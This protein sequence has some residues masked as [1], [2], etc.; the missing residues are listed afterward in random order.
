MCGIVGFIDKKLSF[1]KQQQLKIVENMLDLIK[2]RGGDSCGAYNKNSV[3]TGHT[4]LS[5]VDT[6]PKATQPLFDP[7]SVL[8]LNGEIYNHLKL[9]TLL[10]SD[11]KMHSHSDTHTLFGLLKKLP[12][13]KVLNLIQGMYAFSYF[14]TN[15]NQLALAIDKFSIKPLYYVDTPDYFAWASEMKAFKA[16][17]NFNFEFEDSS[18]VEYLNFRYIYGKKT[19]I[20]KVFK[21]CAGEYLIFDLNRRKK[22][23]RT[24]YK[25][26]RHITTN[27]KFSVDHLNNSVKDNLMGDVSPGV[28]LSGGLDSSLITYF[29]N[30]NSKHKPHTFSIGLKETAWNEFLY[31]NTISHDLKTKHH[32][33]LFSKYDFKN[34]FEKITYHLDEP[35]V[36]PNTI[37]IYLLAKKARKYSKVLLTGEGADEVFLGYRRF[38]LKNYKNDEDFLMSNSFNSI[39]IVKKIIKNKNKILFP[40]RMS[41]LKKIKNID[42]KHKI[43]LYDMHTYL[44]HV[45]LR[46][47]KAGMSANIENRV[48]FLYEPIVESMF[49]TNIETKKFGAKT[50][51]KKIALNFFKKEIVLRNKCGFGLPIHEWLRDE[52]VLLPYLDRIKNHPLVM[53]YFISKTVDIYIS[54]H[55][56]KISDHSSILFTIICL[57]TWYDI[58]ILNQLPKNK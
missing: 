51:L 38:F 6:S 48:P 44:P 50:I 4:R 11:I 32:K 43:S 34:F 33:I 31:S 25:L 19:L 26:F 16:L 17:P 55:K 37:P 21:L 57:T 36:H 29:V 40:K 47:D 10:L 54:E 15:R 24:Y 14:D 53:K 1:K 52:K 30:K 42:L 9:R 49:N 7:I 13:H 58:F 45:L 22:I 3:T 41:L 28:Q 20:K 5:I 39:E 35:I 56:N 12:I 46:Q 23:T 18:L 27:Q 8:S 2:H